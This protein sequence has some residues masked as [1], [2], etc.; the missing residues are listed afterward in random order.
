MKKQNIAPDNQSVTA[1]EAGYILCV[2]CHHL[3]PQQERCD[4]CE[5]PLISRDY[6]SLQHAWAW[7][8]TAAVMIVPANIYPIS[9]VIRFGI[10]T[11]ETILSGIIS[12]AQEDMLFIAIIVFTASILVPIIKIIGLGLI[13]SVVQFRIPMD[14]KWLTVMFH[15]IHW[16]GRWSM[17]DLFVISLMGVLLNLGQNSFD[18]GP[19][20]FAF[21]LTV[22]CTMM[23][24][25]LFDTRLLWDTYD[26]KNHGK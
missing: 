10:V 24:S 25:K 16:I 6:R 23:A 12:L 14:K 26:S 18:P 13:F 4:N 19:A 15:F 5:T 21:G 8:I 20:T 22:V 17:L 9:I 7:L 2:D 1:A 3:N 11:P